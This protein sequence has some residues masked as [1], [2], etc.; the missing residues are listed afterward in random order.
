MNDVNLKIRETETGVDVPLHV[1]PRARRDELAGFHNGALKLRIAAPP[2]E[3][4]ANRSV[5]A[6]LSSLLD[7]PKSWFEMR[8]GPRSRNKV[9]HIRGISRSE[10]LA[11]LNRS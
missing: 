10:F 11:R 1:Q 3:N 6:F 9:L 8:S 7:I 2:V 5:I 4:A